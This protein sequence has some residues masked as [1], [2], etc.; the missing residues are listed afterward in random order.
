[1]RSLRWLSI[2][3]A[4]FSSV[5]NSFDS[6]CL[7]LRASIFFFIFS[8]YYFVLLLPFTFYYFFSFNYSS[9]F[10]PAATAFEIVLEDSSIDCEVIDMMRLR[11]SKGE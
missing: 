8:Y 7:I 9:F 5:F 4:S 11:I 3:L 10:L 1:M 2:S 6:G